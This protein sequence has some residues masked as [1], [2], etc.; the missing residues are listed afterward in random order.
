[1][2]KLLFILFILTTL[3]TYSQEY[4]DDVYY[5]VDDYQE[6][7]TVIEK[8][9]YITNNYYTDYTSRINRFHRRPYYTSYW[10]YYNPYWYYGYYSN[11]LS[12]FEFDKTIQRHRNNHIAG[13][14]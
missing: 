11:I 1:M 10:S 5:T 2:K 9:V 3:T 12:L 4:Y 14:T 13:G 8:D 6:I 7:D